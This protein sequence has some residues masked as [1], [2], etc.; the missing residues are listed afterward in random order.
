MT[1]RGSYIAFEG[2]EASGKS[3]QA[4]ILAERLDAVLTRE[5]G[6]TSL[7]LAVREMLLG[8]GPVPAS[9]TEALLFAADR[10]QH[11]AEVVRPSLEG[12]RHVVTDRSFGSTLAYQGYGRGQ[13]LADLRRLAEWASDGVL[14]DLV[15]LLTVPFEEAEARLGTERDRLEREGREFARRVVDG[16]A[17][18]AFDDPDRWVVVD[19]RGDVD[20]VAER[21]WT[22]YE[23]WR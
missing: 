12:G 6:G 14:P 23:R 2:W 4:S 16:F 3:T 18:L 17:Q 20:L 1:A 5:P 21:V 11:I 15:V 22:A 7:G 13:P 8:D 10:A 19:G 9:R